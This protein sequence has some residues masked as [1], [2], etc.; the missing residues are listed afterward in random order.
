MNV[1]PFC[2]YDFRGGSAPAKAEKSKM[3]GIGWIIAAIGAILFGV[4]DAFYVVGWWSFSFNETLI[5]IGWML[6]GV[7]IMIV[8]AGELS[9]K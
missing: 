7:G 3:V 6:I 9:S 5:A 2:G 4:V 8:G 1:C